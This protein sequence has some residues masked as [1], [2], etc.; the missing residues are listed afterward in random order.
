M[1]ELLYRRDI[2]GLRAVAVLLVLVFHFELLPL[3]VAGFIGVDVF[4]VISG[5]LITAILWRQLERGTFNF[6]SFYAARV[7][8]LAPA[9]VFTLMLVCAY[10]LWTMTPK[11]LTELSRQI[12]AA[13]FYVSNVYFWQNVNYF[14][15]QT[16]QV[17]LLHT[18]SLSVEEQ[19]YLL[20]PALL[21]LV[22]RRWHRGFW[23]VVGGLAMLS[24]AINLAFVGSKPMATFYLLP[25][26]AFEL[27]VGAMLA[28]PLLRCSSSRR[29][30]ESLGVLG[31]GAIVAAIFCYRD[32]IGM[33]GWFALLPVLGAS[34]LLLAAE[35]RRTWTYRVLSTNTMVFIGKISYVAYLVHWPIHVFAR[36][37]WQE[38]YGLPLRSAMFA[39]SLMLAWAVWRWI[40]S[41]V[42]ER[43]WLNGNRNLVVGYGLTLFASVAIVGAVVWSGGLPQRLPP[44]AVKL[45]AYADD[46]SPGLLDCEFH[47][48]QPWQ[49]SR[50][51]LIGTP[52][53][54]PTWVIFG[55]SHAWAGYPG[56]DLWL[57]E[58]GASAWFAFR[59][60]CMPLRGVHLVGDLSEECYRFNEGVFDFLKNSSDINN[61]FFVST[62]YQ[63]P[64]GRLS[65]LP[66]T[67][68]DTK[69]SLD[70]F[71][72]RFGAS[73][74]ELKEAGKRVYLWGPVPG[75]KQNLPR[76]MAMAAW[77]GE[78]A[79]Y[80]ISLEAH[81]HQFA[82]FYA[83]LAQQASQVDV[84][85]V[86]ADELC[87]TGSCRVTDQ[88]RLLYHDNSHVTASTA[89][90]W[91]R[92]IQN[93]ERTKANKP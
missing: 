21:V 46:K 66:S 10:G 23:F 26:R 18:W 19:F 2:D 86:P 59:T 9:L 89:D 25:P 24:F 61:V 15:L 3:G 31:S 52:G 32:G 40:E 92:L 56:F 13:Q 82:F 29:L 76:A 67:H 78:P 28:A 63:A 8:R 49:P 30:N 65:M 55:D 80:E 11:E 22:H 6:Q 45:A 72:R 1:S 90:V 51:C 5:Y 14:G 84:A 53:K 58:R 54:K 60:S 62:W 64:E 34:A 85:V 39:F 91:A 83:E 44:D 75:A 48:A 71:H 47:G 37:H 33:P 70:A 73:M 74:A 81:R 35:D 69:S 7:R 27:L 43:R 87:K 16:D 38:G 79:K 36:S 42:R 68:L 17:P 88:G 77:H 20:Y 57:R 41:P 12:A 93:A 50:N 4:F